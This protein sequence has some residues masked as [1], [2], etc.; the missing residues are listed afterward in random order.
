M[1]FAPTTVVLALAVAGGG[2]LPIDDIRRPWSDETTAPRFHHDQGD[3]PGPAFVERF[4]AL[5]R[6]PNLARIAPATFSRH[7]ATV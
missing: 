7:E 3:Y 1:K 5:S 6:G 2:T 4:A